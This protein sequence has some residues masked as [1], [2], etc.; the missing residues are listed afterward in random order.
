MSNRSNGIVDAVV[1]F[2]V[3]YFVILIVY[4][5]IRVVSMVLYYMIRTQI[6]RI[7]ARREK[8]KAANVVSGLGRVTM[9]KGRVINRA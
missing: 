1:G 4:S 5:V 2:F 6:D 7:I 3:T 8:K 9:Y